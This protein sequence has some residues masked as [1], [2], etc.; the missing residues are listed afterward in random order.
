M[1][2]VVTMQIAVRIP[3]E[4]LARIDAAVAEGRYERRAAAV[5]AGVDRLLREERNREIAER[6]ERG[7]ARHRQ[8]EWIGQAGLTAGGKAVGIRAQA[9]AAEGEQ[10]RGLGRRL[11]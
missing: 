5:R 9:P 11:A 1:V 10:G 2:D 4:H 3:D 7:Y 8:E 6:Y